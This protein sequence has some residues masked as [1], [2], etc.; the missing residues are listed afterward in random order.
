MRRLITAVILFSLAI[1]SASTCW[2]QEQISHGSCSTGKTESDTR[3]TQ[4]SPLEINTHA[5][6]S[7]TEASEEAAKDTEQKNTDTWIIRLTAA[8]AIC[9]FSQFLGILGQIYV[10]LRQTGIMRETLNSITIQAGHMDTQ[11]TSLGHAVKA[12]QDQAF[13]QR[14]TLRPRLSISNLVNNTYA[15]A[16]NGQKVFIN[17][18]I[19]NSGGMPAYGVNVKTWVEF[20]EFSHAGVDRTL[21]FSDQAV[22]VSGGLIN[23]DTTTPQGFQIPFNRRLTD[24]EIYKMSQAKGSICFRIRLDYL[25]FGKEVHTDHALELEDGIGHELANYTSAT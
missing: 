19:S 13:M 25:V 5:I 22:H 15:E 17:L 10:Y 8:I 3:G 2:S 11:T 21:K 12:A 6:Q 9:A 14:E 20:I 7:H 18:K 1:G 4:K 16:R 23:V 24:M